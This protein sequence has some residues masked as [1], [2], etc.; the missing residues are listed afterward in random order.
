MS[1][2]GGGAREKERCNSRDA[3]DDEDEVCLGV[4]GAMSARE[5]LRPCFPEEEPEEES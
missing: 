5:P 3:P 4:N 2:R 1:D